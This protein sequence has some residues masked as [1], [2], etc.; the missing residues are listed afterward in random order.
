MRVDWVIA[1]VTFLMLITWA[2]SYYSLISAGEMV[3]RKEP[4]LQ[5]MGKI[6]DYMKVEF[7][8][9]PANITVPSGADNITVWAYMN[10]TGVG[11]NSARVVKSRF[12]NSSLPC[13]ITGDRIYWKANLTS[14]NN[15]FFVENVE[16][17]EGLNCNQEIA[18]VDNNQS[19][20]WA[21]EVQSIFSSTKISHVCG[22]INQS[23]ESVRNDIG[24]TFDFNVLVEMQESSYTCGLPVPVSAREVFVLPVTGEMWEGGSV[25]LSV[26]LW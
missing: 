25:N 13:N 20:L 3:S 16:S 1:V 14:G 11:M 26:R 2:F 18:P 24:V 7:S 22:L 4:A 17:D 15:Y 23:Y 8:S 6:S 5:A 19:S 10:W 9:T 12:S 21:T